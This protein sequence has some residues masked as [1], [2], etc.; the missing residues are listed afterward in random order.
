MSD[1]EGKPR[2]L[3]FT[4]G[5]SPICD[6]RVR[7]PLTALFEAGDIAGYTVV[8]GD[9]R[10]V[11]PQRFDAYDCIWIQRDYFPWLGT[12]LHERRLPYLL[13]LD[14]LILAMPAY[15]RFTPQSDVGHLVAHAAHISF[16]TPRLRSNCEKYSGHRL[17]DRSSIVPNALLFPRE[18]PV[19]DTPPSA[20]MWTSSDMSSLSRSADQVTRAVARFSEQHGLPIYV[21]GQLQES[22]LARLPRL[23]H[24]GFVNFWAHKAFLASHPGVIGVSPLETDGDEKTLDFVDSKS[25]L[26]ML[27]FG[28]FGHA[29]VYSRCPP[30]TET[31]IR[32]GA[33]AENRFDAWYDALH[34][35]RERAVDADFVRAAEIRRKRAISLIAREAWLPA[36]RGASLPNPIPAREILPPTPDP[37]RVPRRYR[38]VDGPYVFLDRQRH[39]LRRSL[40]SLARSLGG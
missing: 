10:P 14:D 32:T 12:L 39:R 1:G 40:A 8:Y 9:A 21:F 25:D 13:D 18:M 24:F 3:V 30:F 23:R 28:G 31:D 15:S 4:F 11:G 27:E 22:V 20:L 36:L 33:V 29:A 38:M 17:D 7:A 6:L 16:A 5:D 19:R 34:E 37:N 26:K 35:A 2:V